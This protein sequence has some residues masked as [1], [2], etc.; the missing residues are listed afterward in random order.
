QRKLNEMPFSSQN[1]CAIGSEFSGT[2]MEVGSQVTQFKK[3]DRVIGNGQYPFTYKKDVPAGLPTTQ[4]S[5]QLEIFREEKLLKM[6]ENM[7]F[8]VGAAFTIGAQTTYAM[9]KRLQ[10]QENK[11]VL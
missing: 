3:G 4:A 10:I 7:P 9:I 2:V 1:K 8:E 6:P 5:A 11:A